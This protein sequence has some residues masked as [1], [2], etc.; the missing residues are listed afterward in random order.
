MTPDEV[1]ELFVAG[2]RAV[3]SALSDD[4]VADAWDRP[5]VLEE[6][7]VSGLA[8]HLARGGVWV[9]AD[10]LEGGTPS[11]PVDFEGAPQYFVGILAETTAAGHQAIRDRGAAVASVGH[12]ALVRELARRLDAIAPRVT[13]LGPEHLLA[14]AGGNVMRLGDYLATRI[15]E[16]AVHLDDLAQSL[17]REPW[18]YPSAGHE[19][20]IEVATQIL[21]LR[22]GWPATVRALYRR[23]HADLVLPAL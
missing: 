21:C 17:G 5:S 23:G 2:A 10:Y 9:V 8:G 14:V 16:Q 13:A 11:A 19:L 22:H 1:V 20:A 18:P 15:V 7:L 3:A 6:Q 12:E 4:A